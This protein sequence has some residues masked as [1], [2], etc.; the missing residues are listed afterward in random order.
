MVLTAGKVQCSPSSRAKEG[1]RCAWLRVAARF[2]PPPL[3]S[4]ACF[5]SGRDSKAG[6]R[7][8]PESWAWDRAALTY[9]SADGRLA[10]FE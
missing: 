1:A 10:R 7:I 4:M 8:E 2:L 3:R 6:P 5:S 9:P